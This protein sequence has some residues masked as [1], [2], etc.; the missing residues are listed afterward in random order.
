MAVRVV[1]DSSAGLPQRIVEDLDITV[2]DLHLMRDAQEESTSG[3]SALELAAGYARQLERG[4]VDGV[5]Q[6]VVALHI[7]KFL[8]STWNAGVT[9]SA[10]FDDAVEVIDTQNVGM[11]VGAAAM[12]SARIAAQ[13]GSLAECADM[14]RDTLA[15]SETW[16]YLHRIDEIRRSGRITA[17]TAVVS[18]AL[19]TKPIMRINEGR[20]E[21]AARTRTQAKAFARL[22]DL[23]LTRAGGSPAF[24]AIQQ[25][26]ALEAAHTLEEQLRAALPV[27]STI[28]ITE[29]AEILA[30]HCGPGSLGVSAVFR[31]HPHEQPAVDPQAEPREASGAGGVGT[32]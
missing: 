1:V 25:C 19:A 31:D 5:D 18:T 8:S 23:V 28:M 22:V 7:S 17:A 32:P 30:V 21:L 12:A 14:A 20:L 4:A 6:G 16:L 29:M 24:V 27:D 9:A 2:L 15:R 26:E 10:V 3:L 13:G 11:A